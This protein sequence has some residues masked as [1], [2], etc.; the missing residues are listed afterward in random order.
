MGGALLRGWLAQGVSA[1]SIV[2]EEPQLSPEV[3]LLM[4]QNGL[5][6]GLAGVKGALSMAIIAVKPQTMEAVLPLITPI[7]GPDTVIVS[8][9]AGRTLASIERHFAP[10]TAVVRAMPNTPAA[11]GRGITGAVCNTAVTPEQKRLCD[12]LLSAVGEVVWVHDEAFIEAVTAISGSGPA[13]VF[14]F[15]EALAAAGV[16]LGLPPDISGKLA[17]A[18]V[19]GAGELLHQSPDAPSRLRE[20]V[21]SPGGTT[22]AALAVLMAQP[23]LEDLLARATAAAAKR[24][25]E[26]A[27]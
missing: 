13:Y 22:A 27:G 25:Q 10:N 12:Q 26:L 18:T 17:R 16:A 2:I 24:A 15:V 5:V 1:A 4:R 14:H 6:A 3:L 23:G 21:T 9:A 8:V 11:V 20:N 19:T 7:C